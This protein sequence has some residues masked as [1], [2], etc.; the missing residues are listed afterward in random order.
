MA[1]ARYQHGHIKK[2]PRSG[3]AFAWKYYY[4]QTDPDGVRRLKDSSNFFGR[5]STVLSYPRIFRSIVNT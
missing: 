4:R 5:S 1:N 2:V 3:G